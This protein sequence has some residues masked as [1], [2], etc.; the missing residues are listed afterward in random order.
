MIAALGLWWVWVAAA[1]ALG[2]VEVVLPGF[3]FLGFALGALFMAGVVLVL[4]GLSVTAL[5]A[6]FAGLSLICW[7]LLRVAFKRQSSGARIV[8]RDVNEN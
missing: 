3:I 6:V 8:T 4:P 2:I 1:L 5:L 7:I